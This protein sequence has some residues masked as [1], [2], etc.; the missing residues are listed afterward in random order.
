[1]KKMFLKVMILKVLITKGQ[2]VYV[3]TEQAAIQTIICELAAVE[4]ICQCFC[5]LENTN[6]K[7]TFA[8][9]QH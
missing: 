6:F 3:F 2:L 4:N 5:Y 8:E 1:M 9:V 7:G